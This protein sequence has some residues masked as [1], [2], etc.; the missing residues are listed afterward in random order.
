[1]SFH[2]KD[3]RMTLRVNEDY[4]PTCII[5][6]LHEGGHSLYEQG[7]DVGLA[8]TRLANVNSLGLHESQSRLWENCIGKSFAFWRFWY[9]KL[10]KYFPENLNSVSLENFVLGINKVEPSPIR[11]EADE[12][13]YNLHINLR[14]DIESELIN[15]DLEAKEVP[16]VWNSKMQQYLEITPDTDTNGCLQ[17]IHW[18]NGYWGYF[19]TYS[20][21]NI[22]A[23]QISQK[24]IKDFPDLEE[25]VAKGELVFIKDWLNQNIHRWG[26]TYRPDELMTMLTG[27]ALDPSFFE[28]Y[29]EN[30]FGRLYQF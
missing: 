23:A 10:Q 1:V 6:N 26:M 29:L 28:N 2:P 22:Y 12:A 20:L 11:T 18:A 9:P 5:P 24:L 16:E 15:G 21:G 14:Y 3:V 25:R 30:K 17:D 8:R 13:T 19:P 27:S 4:L 7:I